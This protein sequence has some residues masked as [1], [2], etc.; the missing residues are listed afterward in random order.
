MIFFL[1]IQDQFGPFILKGSNRIVIGVVLLTWMIIASIYSSK[2]QPTTSAEQFLDENHPLQRSATILGE[3]IP[4]T[5]ED[6]TAK[7]HFIWG[8]EDVNRGGVNQ[9]FNP[10]FVG[11]AEFPNSFSLNEE[12]QT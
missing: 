1:F 11:T 8:L 7:I 9:L 12:C 3:Q 6:S 2:L 5:A 4:I 10:D